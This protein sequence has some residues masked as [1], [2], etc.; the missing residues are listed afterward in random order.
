M[1]DLWSEI[2]NRISYLDELTEQAADLGVKAA[3][4]DADYRQALSIATA[5]LRGQ[6]MA[7]TVI[8]D[9]LRG[10]A[11]ISSLRLARDCAEA[12]YRANQEAINTQKIAIKILNAQYEREWHG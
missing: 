2:T 3:Q 5:E 8:S 9:I 10:R 1:S 6:G 7:V 12:I 4:A 11:D